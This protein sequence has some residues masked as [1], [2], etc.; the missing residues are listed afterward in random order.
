LQVSPEVVEA[1]RRGDPGAFDDLVRET[2][3][4][5]FSLVFRIVGNR[6]DAADVTQEVYLRVWRGLRTFRGDAELSTWI[7][8]VAANTALTFLKRRGRG[9][10]VAPDEMP[11]IPVEDRTDQHADADALERAL[12]SLPEAQRAVVVLKDVYGWSCEEIG[13]KMGATEGAV[14]VRLFRARRRLADELERAGVV[15][16]IQQRKRSS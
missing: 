1:A 2:H 6:D 11:E 10:P 14:K 16:P 3:R 15:G 12:G 4:A 5:V 8:R 7:H 13:K 9:A